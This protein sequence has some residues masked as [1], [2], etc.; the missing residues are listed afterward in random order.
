MDDNEETKI[1]EIKRETETSTE[2]QSENLPLKLENL[3]T[4]EESPIFQLVQNEIQVLKKKTPKQICHYLR[5]N[6]ISDSDQSYKKTLNQL[7]L[8]YDDNIEDDLTQWTQSLKYNPAT[9]FA[10][11]QG[12]ELKTKANDILESIKKDRNVYQKLIDVVDFYILSSRC[13]WGKPSR[14]SL[15]YKKVGQRILKIYSEIPAGSH[16]MIE[17]VNYTNIRSLSDNEFDKLFQ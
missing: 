4:S 9:R 17:N 7:Q 11:L 13:N 12:D 5:K 15:D 2:S 16:Y 6:P 10:D 14:S 3:G 8:Q 1:Y